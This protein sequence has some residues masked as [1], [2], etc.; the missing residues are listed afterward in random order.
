M[1]CRTGPL[2]QQRSRKKS[3]VGER[4]AEMD[5]GAGEGIKTAPQRSAT[6]KSACSLSPLHPLNEPMPAAAGNNT[7]A[8]TRRRR[9]ISQARFSHVEVIEDVDLCAALTGNHI[10]HLDKLTGFRQFLPIPLLNT[11]RP[12][13]LPSEDSYPGNFRS[14]LR[15]L[16]VP[17]LQNRR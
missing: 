9:R 3:F 13:T 12:H 8:A 16:R 10:M 1:H 11:C 14:P 15:R 17:L 7:A 4:L 5:C 6:L 2:Q